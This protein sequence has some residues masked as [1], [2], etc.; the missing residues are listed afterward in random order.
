MNIYNVRCL[1][2]FPSIIVLC[3]PG[4]SFDYG[5]CHLP[6]TCVCK[7]NGWKGVNCTTPACPDG[8]VNGQCNEPFNCTCNAG[9][10]G[11][12]CST[13]DCPSSC[14]NGMCRDPH[15][16]TCEEGWTGM[17]CDEAVCS[18]YGCVNGS[19]NTPDECMCY[20]GWTG[21]DCSIA[22]CLGGDDCNGTCVVPGEC[23]CPPD[24]TGELCRTRIT[25]PPPTDATEGQALTP[26][27]KIILNTL[28]VLYH[29][30]DLFLL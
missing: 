29:D 6:N 23:I 15:I 11:I 17:N 9:W 21:N 18:T 5:T 25:E 10:S 8:C 22:I 14:M 28:S 7:N 24:Y 20:R 26:A 4:C 13:A 19:C 1:R 2:C 12:D 27:G 16:C 30:S 3:S